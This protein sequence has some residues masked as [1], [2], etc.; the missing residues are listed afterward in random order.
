[1]SRVQAHAPVDRLAYFVSKISF[2][3]LPDDVV[4]KTKVHVADT[5]GAALAGA[6]SAEAAIAR[7][8][9]GTPG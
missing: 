1:M 7:R 5:I 8:T 3:T 4:E 6:C 9:A 2:E